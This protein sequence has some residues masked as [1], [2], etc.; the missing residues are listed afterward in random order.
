MKKRN[1]V[2]IVFALKAEAKPFIKELN[3][4]IIEEKPVPIFGNRDT[5]ITISGIGK[6]NAAIAATNLINRFKAGHLVN[7]G[8]AGSAGGNFRIGDI[9]HIDK[10]FELDRPRLLSLKPTI[11]EPD[12]LKGLTTASLATRDKP[13]LTPRERAAAARYADLVDMEAAAVVQACRAFG[14]KVY[15]FKVVTDTAETNKMEIIKNILLTRSALFE[16]FV[17]KIRPVL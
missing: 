11:H 14:V 7:L 3:L 17:E 15:V 8:A 1:F 13:A 2:S 16:F 4:S 5:V 6:V 10:I 12:I 9:L